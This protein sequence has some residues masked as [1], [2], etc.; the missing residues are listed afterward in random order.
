M[1][2]ATR[3]SKS[4]KQAVRWRMASSESGRA[5][6]LTR[7]GSPNLGTLRGERIR[8]A[9]RLGD[10]VVARSWR[11]SLGDPDRL[12]VVDLF[13]GAGGFALG[14]EQAGFVVAAGIDRND[15]AC[16]TFGSNLTAMGICQDLSRVSDPAALLE[17]HAIPRVDVL[18]G[19]PPCQGFSIV[20]RA[21]VRSLGPEFQAVVAERNRLYRE[22]VRFVEAL[23][24]RA[25]VME[26]VPH[27]GT[28]GDGQ[29]AAAIQEDFARLGYAV[30]SVLLDALRFGVPQTRRRLFFFGSRLG[31]PTLRFL[32]R[33]GAPLT[34]ADAI[35]DLPPLQAPSLI[36]ALPYGGPALPSAQR[37]SELRTMFRASMD[38]EHQDLVYDHVVRAVREDDA[39]VF[40]YMK[41]GD[42]YRD[43]DPSHRRYEIKRSPDGT[44]EYFAD[45]YFRLS[46]Q[47]PCVT[48][49]AHLAKDGY[50]YIHPDQPRTLSVREAA[51]VQTFPDSFRFAG[52]RSNR[53]IQIGNAVPPLLAR[54]VAE[55]VRTM[56]DDQTGRTLERARR[57]AAASL[58]GL[59]PSD[60]L[61]VAS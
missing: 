11:Q 23:R 3:T 21:K 8:L 22:F 26:N 17:T 61:E 28:F 51:R 57:A 37:T 39:R 38:G 50:R 1:G 41:P 19:G 4:C 7:A 34:L 27:M 25:F 47:E 33:P 36:E 30:Q 12:S 54:A 2:G 18:I 10:L 43:V 6:P 16:E 46:W 60:P 13:C 55:A 40:A 52:Y 44:D 48:I 58:H 59:E 15:D 32:T 45:R 14:F 53:F 56:L 35:G 29:I 49:T 31:H 20:G 9:A 5:E 24:P 42:R